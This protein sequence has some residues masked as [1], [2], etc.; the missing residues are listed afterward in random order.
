MYK[1]AIYYQCYAAEALRLFVSLLT[2]LDIPLFY[3]PSQ[4]ALFFTPFGA[5]PK[6]LGI[7]RTQLQKYPYNRRVLEIL[8][9]NPL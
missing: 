6:M 3:W 5:H 1:V 7:G 4:Y 2:T 8:D 9:K